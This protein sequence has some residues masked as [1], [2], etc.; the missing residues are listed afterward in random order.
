MLAVPTTY[1]W[2]QLYIIVWEGEKRELVHKDLIYDTQPSGEYLADLR[3][4]A[5]GTV[6]ILTSTRSYCT[7]IVSDYYT[8]FYV[9]QITVEEAE[10]G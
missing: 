6:N 9:S 4:L 2:Y 3:I 8:S 5:G 1:Y 10:V 7:Q